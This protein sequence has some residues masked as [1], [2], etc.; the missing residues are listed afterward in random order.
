MACAIMLGMPQPASYTAW[1]HLFGICAAILIQ[2]MYGS[3]SCQVEGTLK[4][5]V[6]AD[7][8]TFLVTLTKQFHS[9]STMARR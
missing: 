5:L 9:A 1:H 6:T 3:I 7:D 2:V 4:W 8:V